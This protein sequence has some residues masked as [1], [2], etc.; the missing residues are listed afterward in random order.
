VSENSVLKRV[1]GTKTE[2]VA[3]GCGSRHTEELHNLYPSPIIGT[4]IK[5]RMMKWTGLVTSMGEMRSAYKI[6]DGKPEWKEPLGRR[7]LR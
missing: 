2:K 1:F 5:S 6:L 3:E 4:V 7:K